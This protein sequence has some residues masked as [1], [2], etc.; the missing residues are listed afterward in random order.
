MLTKVVFAVSAFPLLKTP[1]KITYFNEFC[2]HKSAKAQNNEV[3]A[4]TK[5]V[6]FCFTIIDKNKPC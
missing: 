1:D 4:F 5:K 2:F 3:N 6:L